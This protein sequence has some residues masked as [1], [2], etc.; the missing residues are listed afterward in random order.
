M[1]NDSGD[2][3]SGGTGKVI[4]SYGGE[5]IL[6]SGMMLVLTAVLSGRSGK[7]GWSCRGKRAV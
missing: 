6:P 7:D 2:N 4:C 1:G 5:L 3:R